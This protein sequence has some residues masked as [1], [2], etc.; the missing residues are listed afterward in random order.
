MNVMKP[1]LT[2]FCCQNRECPDYGRRA[3]GNLAV[4]SWYGKNKQYRLLYCHSC[5]TR[6]SERKGTVLFYSQLSEAKIALLRGYLDRGLRVRDIAQLT[7]VNRNTVVRY[8][9]LFTDARNGHKS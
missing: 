4:D 2:G 3:K 5:G 7:Q 9:R 6:F 8:H 1:E